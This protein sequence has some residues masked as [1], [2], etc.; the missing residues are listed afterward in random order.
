MIT[1]LTQG[2]E[3]TAA[4]YSD[5]VRL[6]ERYT[7]GDGAADG[8]GGELLM[9]HASVE[10]CKG[11]LAWLARD[12]DRALSLASTFRSGEAY[13]A[14]T[15]PAGTLNVFKDKGVKAFRN[16]LEVHLEKKL[17]EA[18]APMTTAT[19]RMLALAVGAW[20]DGDVLCPP[21]RVSFSNPSSVLAQCAKGLTRYTA[22]RW[23]AILVTE[24]VGGA[25][26]CEA[27]AAGEK[28]GLLAN[29]T[30]IIEAPWCTEEWNS[31]F[32]ELKLEHSKTGKTHAIWTCLV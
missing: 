11:F 26:L 7:I 30:S 28:H 14:K 19:P 2:S 25:R 24:G 21:T 5:Y 22:A 29:N 10:A 31:P 9:P 16:D 15:A 13:V 12:A 23:A 18:S 1:E 32:V 20:Y 27:A 17:G 3:S 4:S 6:A 8:S